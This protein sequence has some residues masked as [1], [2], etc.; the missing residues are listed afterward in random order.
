MG[1]C[2]AGNFI[3]AR[4]TNKQTD[5]G[6]DGKSIIRLMQTRLLFGEGQQRGAK[7]FIA[8]TVR[9]VLENLR[10]ATFPLLPKEEEKKKGLDHLFR[11][12]RTAASVA[13]V[14]R[15]YYVPQVRRATQTDSGPQSRS[16]L[17]K[18]SLLRRS[19]SCRDT[20][21]ESLLE[22]TNNVD[23]ITEELISD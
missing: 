4:N 5:I 3:G 10:F 13:S 2:T 21:S 8:T 14:K 6:D 9:S 11:V 17:Q 15:S 18:T 16:L 7:H 20:T 23:I 12:A 1:G 22:N 19:G